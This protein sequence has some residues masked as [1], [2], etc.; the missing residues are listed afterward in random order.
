MTGAAGTTT[1][2]GARFAG[3]G[4]AVGASFDTGTSPSGT[5]S[6]TSPA[7]IHPPAR[8]GV[9]TCSQSPA[10]VRPKTVSGVSFATFALIAKLVPGPL[11]TRAGPV[12]SA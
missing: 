5:F 10:G 4:A 12:A 7:E 2:A 6:R 1:G 9:R 8:V 11:R 3:A